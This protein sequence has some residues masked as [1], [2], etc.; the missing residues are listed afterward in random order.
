MELIDFFEPVD[1]SKLDLRKQGHPLLLCESIKA[2]TDTDGFPDLDQI[3]IAIIGVKED[4]NGPDNEGC[5]LAPDYVRKYL[6]QL[7]QGPFKTRV[8]DLGNIRAGDQ[9]TDTYFAVKTVVAELIKQKVI[10][11]IIGGTQDLTYA[12][13]QAYED[14]GQ[15]INI[16]SIDAS[17]DIGIHK[18]QKVNHRNYLSTIL[19]HQPNYLFNYTNIGYQT[20]FVDQDAIELMDQLFF[21]TY[22]LGMVRQNLEEVEPVVRNADLLSVDV[23][24][25]RQSDAPG[26]VNASP[27]GFYG[28]EACQIIRYAGLSDKLSSIGFYEVNPAFDNGEQTAHLV[29]Q[30]IW[31]F[32]DGFYHRKNDLPDRNRKESGEYLKYVVTIKDF[33]N[34][35]VFYKSKKSDRWW[36]EVPCPMGMQAKY[37]RQ[38][39]VPCSY[40]E[41]QAACQDEIPDKW[42]Q[43]Y[44]KFM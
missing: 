9:V 34:E 10:P 22:R 42:W 11:L 24:S 25:I 43:V 20:Y 41:Y 44:Q 3:D 13:Y 12:N 32:L 30:M 16:V 21:D 33:Q 38:L 1:K 31:Y 28:E 2:F 5:S 40:K 7:F 26:N 35:I 6:Y 4:R 14:L 27:N 8:A 15:I 23:S 29:A 18:N 17:F 39:L 36:M 19:T 37:E